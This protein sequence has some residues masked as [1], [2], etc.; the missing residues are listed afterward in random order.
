MLEM[1]MGG[2]CMSGPDAIEFFENLGDVI[3]EETKTEEFCT[4]FTMAVNRLRY[5]VQKNIR[6]PVRESKGK[7]LTSYSCG[8]CGRGLDVNDRYCSGCGRQAQW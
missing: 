7:R 6:F 2:R 4:Q 8:Y 1:T 3:D 5:E